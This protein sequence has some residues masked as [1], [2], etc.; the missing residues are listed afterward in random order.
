MEECTA[1]NSYFS[2]SP[3]SIP[4]ITRPLPCL[5]TPKNPHGIPI[6][7]IFHFYFCAGNIHPLGGQW[8]LSPENYDWTVNTYIGYSVEPSCRAVSSFL[9]PTALIY[10]SMDHEYGWQESPYIRHKEREM[11]PPRAYILAKLLRFFFA[12]EPTSYSPEK[13]LFAWSQQTFDAATTATNITYFVGASRDLDRDPPGEDITV[14]VMKQLPSSVIGGGTGEGR[15]SQDEFV[16]RV[17]GSSALIGVGMPI[18]SP[19]PYEALCLGVPLINPIFHWDH[20]NPSDRS[21]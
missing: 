9:T 3:S 13:V 11:N 1:S 4:T 17:S 6:Y 5:L 21:S 16:K 15:V 18:T 20:S 19:T 2:G 10:P 12:A 7:K 8:T 14:N